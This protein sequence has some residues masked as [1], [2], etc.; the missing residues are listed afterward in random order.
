[1]YLSPAVRTIRDDPVE[2]ES[3]TLLLEVA[4]DA[5]IDEVAAALEAAGATVEEELQFRTLQ[6]TVAHERVGAVCEADGIA[7]V[8]TGNTLGLDPDEAEGA[9]EDVRP[10]G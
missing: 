3:V 4:D 2:G 1:M 6:A 8:E 7:H 9:G 10:G 5:A